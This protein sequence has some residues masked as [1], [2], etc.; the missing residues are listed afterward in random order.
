MVPDLRDQVGRAARQDRAVFQFTT[1]RREL[2]ITLPDGAAC[3]P[4]SVQ[5]NG[6]PVTPRTRA[7]RVLVVPLSADAEPPRYYVLCLKYHFPGQRP[8]RGAMKFEF[9]GLGDEAWIRRAYWQLLLPPEE[10]LVT[11]PRDL[12]GEFAWGWNKFYFGRQP[13]L[14]QA[15]LDAWCG[16]SHPGS[17]PV[18]VGMNAYLFS[19]L[20][21]FGPCE[22]VTAGRS[23]IVFLSSALALLAGLLLI[24]VR[25]V[26]HPA[27]LLAAAVSLAGATATYPELALIAAQASAIGLGLS[28]LALLLR[29]LTAGGR[30]PQT[31]EVSSSVTPIL[32]M[33]QP[34]ETQVPA[35]AAAGSSRKAI[36]PLPPDAAT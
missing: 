27:V 1:R 3:E 28:L 35:A 31:P 33:P 26:R 34:S 18:P 25:T 24:Y 12:T 2:E 32:A 16:L 36:V 6:A 17:T 5:L 15:D 20:D 30:Q 19:S 11:S 23:T 29:Y 10:H 9:A 14:N 8:S 21:T 4:A 7:G 22:I 13:V